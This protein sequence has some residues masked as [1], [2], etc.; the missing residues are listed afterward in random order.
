MLL[1]NFLYLTGLPLLSFLELYT[2]NL[3]QLYF[4]FSFSLL[5]P[6]ALYSIKTYWLSFVLYLLCLG[7]LDLIASGILLVVATQEF[8]LKGKSNTISIASFIPFLAISLRAVI[9]IPSDHIIRFLCLY[10]NI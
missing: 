10:G 4:L 3:K 6:L 9:S 8:K 2:A 1:S 5:L 7:A